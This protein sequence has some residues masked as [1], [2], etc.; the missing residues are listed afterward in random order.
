MMQ[1]LQLVVHNVFG[2]PESQT[3]SGTSNNDVIWTN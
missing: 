1:L 2:I 3:S